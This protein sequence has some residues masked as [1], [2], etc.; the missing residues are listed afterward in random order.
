MTIQKFDPSK[1][2]FTW[3]PAGALGYWSLKLGDTHEVCLE[4]T[5][6]GNWMLAMYKDGDL[7]TEEKFDLKSDI[8]IP[9]D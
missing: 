7:I 9:N 6:F 3:I 4:P 2:G 8:E 1:S 5:L